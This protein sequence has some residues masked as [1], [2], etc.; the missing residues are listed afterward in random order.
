MPG[1]PKVIDR[2]ALQVAIAELG[3]DTTDLAHVNLD[4]YEATLTYY[5]TNAE[6]KKL[7]VDGA[8]AQVVH[9]VPIRHTN[10][11]LSTAGPLGQ[12]AGGRAL[13]LPADQPT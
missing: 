12:W 8:V 10:D 4:A 9:T 3:I 11:G 5:V 6:G 7:L 13:A 1:V 2:A